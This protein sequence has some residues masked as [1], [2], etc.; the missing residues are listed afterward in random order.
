MAILEVKPA[1]ALHT[2]TIFASNTQGLV[3]P[4]ISDQ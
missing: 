4:M 1:S 2:I 3:I